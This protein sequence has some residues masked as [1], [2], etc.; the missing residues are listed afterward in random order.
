M[1]NDSNNAVQQWL[2]DIPPTIWRE[3][4]QQ[5]VVEAGFGAGPACVAGRTE[6]FVEP[7]SIEEGLGWLSRHA[8]VLRVAH[9]QLE[10]RSVLFFEPLGFRRWDRTRQAPPRAGIVVAH[11]PCDHG[12]EEREDR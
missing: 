6:T 9:L 5:E 1:E 10:D 2:R 11:P 7:V 3:V 12:D 8:G 4:R